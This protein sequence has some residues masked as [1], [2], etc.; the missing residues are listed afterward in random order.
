MDSKAA[1]SPEAIQGRH[2]IWRR[3]ADDSSGSAS[4][5]S[6]P[7][8]D[9]VVFKE[10]STSA[11]SVSEMKS[12]NL[13][14]GTSHDVELASKVMERAQALLGLRGAWSKGSQGHAEGT[15]KPCS[16]VHSSL[17]C[18]LGQSCTFCHLP[19]VQCHNQNKNRPSK[20]KRAHCKRLAKDFEMLFGDKPEL[21]N[22]VAS[23]SSYMRKVMSKS[24]G[25]STQEMLFNSQPPCTRT[26]AGEST[27]VAAAEMAAVGKGASHPSNST[28]NRVPNLVT[29]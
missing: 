27:A 20:V 16:F 17:G 1:T 21:L 26:H 7:V 18:N 10:W 13:E 4:H 29:L 19:H 12:T 8:P 3:S 24:D 14:P 28:Q 2:V 22:D 15:C 11:E 23:Q 5:G 25:N 6:I 9:N